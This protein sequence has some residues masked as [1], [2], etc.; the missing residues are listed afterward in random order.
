MVIESGSTS[1]AAGTFR[2]PTLIQL[3]RLTVTSREL[4]EVSWKKTITL[5]TK[6]SET[7]P[8]AT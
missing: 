4:L 6:L 7:A 8:V 5:A 3:K 1:N 2:D